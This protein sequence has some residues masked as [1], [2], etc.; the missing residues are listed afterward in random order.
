MAIPQRFDPVFGACHILLTEALPHQGPV[1]FKLRIG[2][3]DGFKFIA[4][5]TPGL[6]AICFIGFLFFLLHQ[7]G[8]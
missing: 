3:V 8:V 2:Y 7:P 4:A 5:Q 1:G 6:T